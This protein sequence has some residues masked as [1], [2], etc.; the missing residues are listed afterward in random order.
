M[1]KLALAAALVALSW[2][3]WGGSPEEVF[4]SSKLTEIEDTIE[5]AISQKKCPGGVFWLEHRGT[6]FH[7][8]FGARALVPTS[9]PAAEDT[10]YDAASLTKVMATTPAIMILL[11][12]GQL[13]LDA[14]VKDYWPEF[15]QHGKEAITIR[16]LL[17]HTSGLRPGL[18]PAPPGR[19]VAWAQAC[20][21]KTVA[22]PG[23]KFRYSDINFITL[24]ALVQRVSGQP[25]EVFCAQ[26]IYGPL[27]MQ[28]TGYLPT[29]DRI[30]PT[31]RETARGT[32]HDP[33]AARM[34][35][36]AGHAGLFTTA[37]DLARYAR[38]LLGGGE[39]EGA[40][41]FQPATVQ[42]MTSVQSP[43]AVWELRG[44]G[45]DIDTPYSGPRG[46]HFILGSYGHTGWTG[47]SVWIDPTSQSFVIFLSN[48]NHPTEAGNV[49]ALRRAL[50]T[51]GAEAIR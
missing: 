28:D 44:L 37:S 26:E 24:G 36:V 31:T 38:A 6:S 39:L 19:E 3:A 16:H 47:T 27:K 49:G 35:G 4:H 5:R 20:A 7:R 22:T 33:T 14:P 23:T 15:G 48:R 34:G 30:A 2:T 13:A 25:L 42:L 50:G 43:D 10:I 8:A 46:E 9:E 45:W 11:E 1:R 12:R 51:L 29:S 17:T 40:R 21:E 41:V 32:V 18:A